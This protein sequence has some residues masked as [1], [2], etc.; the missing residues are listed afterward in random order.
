MIN[1]SVKYH[2]LNSSFLLD[3]SS[4]TDFI[5]RI[6]NL[7]IDN[8]SIIELNSL[9]FDERFDTV[10]KQGTLKFISCNSKMFNCNLMMVDS[11]MPLLLSNVILL[12]YSKNITDITDIGKALDEINPL[13]YFGFGKINIYEFKLKEFLRSLSLGMNS[14]D[15]W[16]GEPNIYEHLP[17]VKVKDEII[18]CSDGVKK[19]IDTLYDYSRIGRNKTQSISEIYAQE[20]EYFIKLNLQIEL[21]T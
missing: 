19:F 10:N 9:E 20:E 18:Y 7:K 13:D 21:K 8:N 3:G 6:D 2:I 5:Y 14:I 4:N 16:N 1:Q 12:S 17:V 11:N 15:V